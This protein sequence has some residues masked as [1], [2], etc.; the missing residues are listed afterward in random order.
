EHSDQSRLYRPSPLQLSPTRTAEISEDGSNPTGLSQDG[1]ELPALVTTLRVTPHFLFGV[2]N[3]PM[4]LPLPFHE[5]SELRMLDQVRHHL[6]GLTTG[7]GSAIVREG[8]K[9]HLD[10]DA[11]ERFVEALRHLLTHIEKDE[12]EEEGGIELELNAIGRGF[13]QV[14]KIQHPFGD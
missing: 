12:V 5:A 9:S 11:F 2:E 10:R 4:A 3:L 1:A 14:S 7:E 8:S 13:P 6:N